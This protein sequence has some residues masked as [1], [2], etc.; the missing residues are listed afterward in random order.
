MRS[1]IQLQKI[2]TIEMLIAE[3]DE[4]TALQLAG[5]EIDRLERYESRAWT[6]QKRAMRDFIEI[7]RSRERAEISS[8]ADSCAGRHQ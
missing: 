4:F 1:E 5:P 8:S 7:S 3:M 2:R 6:R